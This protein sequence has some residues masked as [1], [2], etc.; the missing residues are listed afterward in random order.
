MKK[1]RSESNNFFE[2]EKDSKKNRKTEEKG[3][4]D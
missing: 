3:L 1:K 2:S 4:T